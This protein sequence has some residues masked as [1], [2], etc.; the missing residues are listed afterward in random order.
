MGGPANC[1]GDRLAAGLVRGFRSESGKN[2]IRTGF[3]NH[4]DPSQIH[5]RSSPQIQPDPFQIHPRNRRK[6]KKIDENR[7]KWRTK[8]DETRRKP[9]KT[10]ENQRK[11]TKTLIPVHGPQG[12]YTGF[13]V[14]DENRRKST[15]IDRVSDR[16][17]GRGCDRGFGPG[18]DQGSTPG[19][20]QGSGPISGGVDLGWIWEGS[21]WIWGVDLR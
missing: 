14:F 17:S 12:P 18:S 20:D 21:G 19:S 15:K 10:E 7:R 16:G 1:R 9:K 3:Q 8:I 6:S 5:L 13:K 2:R 11:S 4:S